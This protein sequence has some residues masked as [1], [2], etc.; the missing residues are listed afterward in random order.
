MTRRLIAI[1]SPLYG[2][3]VHLLVDGIHEITHGLGEHI[4]IRCV[5]EK[6]A[7]YTGIQEAKMISIASDYLVPVGV[8]IAIGYISWRI[9]GLKRPSEV[10]CQES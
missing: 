5:L 1:L 7:Y 6:L 8:I 4:A 3:A 10:E 2:E 9:K